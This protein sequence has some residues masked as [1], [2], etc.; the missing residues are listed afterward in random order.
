MS[1]VV[2]RVRPSYRCCFDRYSGN[3]LLPAF[4]KIKHNIRVEILTNHSVTATI[5]AGSH[6]SQSPAHHDLAY[7]LYIQLTGEKNFMLY[8][9]SAVCQLCI[10]GR[11]HPHSRQSRYVDIRTLK[12]IN[13]T[14]SSAGSAERW[15]S[16]LKRIAVVRELCKVD[17]LDGYEVSLMHGDVL[18]IPPFWY[19]EVSTFASLRLPSL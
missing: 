6:G 19:H 16:D 15:Y 11:Y 8:P 13:T 1:F 17:Q 18:F 12:I 3:V 2:T 4:Q 10:H 7:N 14:R 9:H 5:W